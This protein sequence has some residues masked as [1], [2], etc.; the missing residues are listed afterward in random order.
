MIK[1][2][3]RGKDAIPPKEKKLL[4]IVGNV[5]YP[6]GNGAHNV[7]AKNLSFY[8]KYGFSN[9]AFLTDDENLCKYSILALLCQSYDKAVKIINAVTAEQL[10]RY[11]CAH[12]HLVLVNENECL[13]PSKHNSGI[14][15]L[16][17]LLKDYETHKVLFAGKIKK[18]Y[19]YLKEYIEIP[20]PS[21]QTYGK[22]PGECCRTYF[23]FDYCDGSNG[24]KLDDFKVL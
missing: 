8:V 3:K 17:A 20:H 1:R 19:T 10:A 9:V 22:R 23:H 16:D 13:M 2:I 7:S 15:R 11:L 6:S 18:Q 5:P 12:C 24:L 4:V 14:N 21:S